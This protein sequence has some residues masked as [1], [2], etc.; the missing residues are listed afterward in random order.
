[1]VAVSLKKNFFQAEDGIRDRSPSRGLG[2]VYKRQGDELFAGE[3]DALA[4][5]D[6]LGVCEEVAPELV[7]SLPALLVEELVFEELIGAGAA[8]PPVVTAV[9][10]WPMYQDAPSTPSV[11]TP[12]VDLV[13]CL[14]RQTPLRESSGLRFQFPSGSLRPSE[15]IGSGHKCRHRCS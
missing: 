14:T 9:A 6:A 5:G 1:M 8:K 11:I 12:I 15:S 2:D 3:L 4:L 10:D 7:L 13:D